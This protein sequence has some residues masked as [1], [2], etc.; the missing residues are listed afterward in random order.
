MLGVDP[1]T[2]TAQVAPSSTLASSSSASAGSRQRGACSERPTRGEGPSAR[3]R[4]SVPPTRDGSKPRSAT[5]AADGGPGFARRRAGSPSRTQL[6]VGG[7]D[8]LLAGPASR[9]RREAAPC[10]RGGNFGGR[11]QHEPAA[12]AAQRPPRGGR[13]ARA[14]TEGRRGRACFERPTPARRLLGLLHA[15]DSGGGAITEPVTTRRP[16]GLC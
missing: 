13:R 11:P 15:A 2:C 16:P 1:R 10:R 7:A 5:V 4:G 12:T 3:D 9:G 14:S 8:W 6:L